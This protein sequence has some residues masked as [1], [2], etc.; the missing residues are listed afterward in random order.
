MEDDV[1]RRLVAFAEGDDNIRAV[2]VEGSRAFGK[3]D[4]YSDYD[5]VFVARSNEPYFGGAILPLMREWFG[6]IVVMQTPDDGDPHDVYT[7]LIQFS[8]GSRVDLTFNSL[9]FQSCFPSESATVAL[10]D[11]DG[12]FSRLPPPS[13]RD[14]WVKRP[15]ADQF[16][17]C[18][19]EFWWVSTYVAKAVARGQALH[20]LE[21]LNDPVRRE[22]ARMLTWLAGADTDFSVSVGHLGGDMAP[23]VPKAFFDVLLRSYPRA[24]CGEIGDALD[25]MMRAFPD[26]AQSVSGKLGYEYDG[27]EGERTVEFIEER[28][29]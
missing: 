25:G 23:Y 3:V 18:C 7:H 5:V 4:D 16:R 17:A 28:L 14:Y 26:I 19:N 21:L 15:T 2:L 27:G 1:L 29:R 6:E 12:M 9:E 22:F 13:D 20:A 11:K 24:E 10:V 8:S